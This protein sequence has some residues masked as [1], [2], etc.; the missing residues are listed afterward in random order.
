MA[1]IITNMAIRAGIRPKEVKRFLKFGVVGTLGF[2]I[3]FGLTILLV[4]RFQ[5]LKLVANAVG[6]TMAVCSNFTLN[7][8]WTYPDSRSKHIGKQLIQFGL[9]NFIGLCINSTTFFLLTPVFNHLLKL[10][11]YSIVIDRGY[12]P[13]KMVAT[14]IVLFWNFFINRKWTYN[15]VH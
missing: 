5:F 2:I 9:V 15:D 8:Y 11:H 6:F 1:A 12:I 3:D 7:R 13:A 4:E 14:G 10:S